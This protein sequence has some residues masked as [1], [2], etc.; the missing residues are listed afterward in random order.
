MRLGIFLPNWIG[1]VV[2]ATPSLRA[3]RQHIGT[4]GQ[5]VGIMRPYVAE[6]LAGK[7]WFDETIL[8]A[9]RPTDAQYAW[10]AVRPRLSAARLDTILLMTNS[11]RTAWMAWRSVFQGRWTAVF[12]VA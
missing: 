3:L 11:L 1:D 12:Q 7:Q 8:Y 6:V 5:L 2:M 10:S 4:E 9:K